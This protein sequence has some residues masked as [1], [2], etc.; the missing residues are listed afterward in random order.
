MRLL[1]SDPSEG[2]G[3]EISSSFCCLIAIGTPIESNNTEAGI[4]SRGNHMAKKGNTAQRHRRRTLL[5]WAFA[6][7]AVS[8]SLIGGWL[9]RDVILDKAR[10]APADPVALAAW[11]LGACKGSPCR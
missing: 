11:S 8:I 9:G 1:N 5:A 6:V 4:Y 10:H 3:L 2:G 7:L